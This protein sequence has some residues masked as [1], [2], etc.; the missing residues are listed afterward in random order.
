MNL[1]LWELYLEMVSDWNWEV[2]FLDSGPST[3]NPNGSFGHFLCFDLSFKMFKRIRRSIGGFRNSFWNPPN[4]FWGR[5]SSFW[6][7][8]N[9]FGVLRG[10]V[11]DPG[12][13]SKLKISSW[14]QGSLV[15]QRSFGDGWSSRFADSKLE[16]NFLICNTGFVSLHDLLQPW[17]CST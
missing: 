13:S 5:I 8:I 11:W 2:H 6:D 1:E 3:W 10:F 7:S 9:S 12:S 17:T 16:W 4:L 15:P 14:D